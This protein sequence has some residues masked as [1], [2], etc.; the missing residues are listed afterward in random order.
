MAN[1]SNDPKKSLGT[2]DD[3]GYVMICL[4]DNTIVPIARDDEH[5]L[6]WDMMHDLGIDGDFIP[7]YHGNN[8]VHRTKDVEP[9][10]AATKKWLSYG[11]P[12][13]I[14]NIYPGQ[15]EQGILSM[16]AFAKNGIKNMLPRK[17]HVSEAGMKIIGGFQTI[18]DLM[19]EEMKRRDQ[20]LPV[21]MTG[22]AQACRDL[23]NFLALVMKP[24]V[25]SMTA[26]LDFVAEVEKHRKT[27]DLD[28]FMNTIFG[29]HGLKNKIHQAMKEEIGIPSWA[30]SRDVFWGDRELAI[31][32]LAKM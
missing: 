32:L 29:F 23:G 25:F 26:A 27:A 16:K 20:G 9:F 14:V 2:M 15:R 24:Y 19:V 18:S 3:V 1:S 7:V 28:W 12:D 13:G 21:R 6:G 30:E 5:N 22:I 11:G 31:D 4:T 10:R 17:G 8:Y